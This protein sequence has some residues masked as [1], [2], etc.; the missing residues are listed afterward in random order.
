MRIKLYFVTLI[1]IV[2]TA[3]TVGAQSNTFTYQGRLTDNNVAAGGTYEM[4]FR[5][6][7]AATAGNQL[8]QP[9]PVTLT[10][11]IAGTNP[12]T[13]SNGVFTVK[14]D[15]G[16]GVFTGADRWL[17]IS[18]RKPSDPPGFT[19]LTPRQPITS[20]PYS[21]KTLNANAADSLSSACILC[22]TDAQI[23]GIDGSKVT[24]SVASATT[25]GSATTST[26]AATATNALNLGGLAAN[27][28]LQKNGD[29]SLLTNIAGTFKWNVIAGTSQQAVG[30]NGYVAND[31]GQ[32]TITLPTSPNIGDTIR[33]AAAGIGGFLIAQNAGQ[34]ILTSIIGA[35]TNV[36]GA[37]R[38][39]SVASSSDGT[40]LVAAVNGGQ[41]YT[42]NDSGV[43]WTPRESNRNW[44]SVAS[45]SDGTKLVAAFYSG[46]IYTSTDS[47]VTWFP[48]DS[49]RLWRSVASSSDGTKLVAVGDSIRVYTSTDSGVTWTPRDS[50][51]TWTSVASSSDGTKLVAVVNGGQIYTSTDSGVTWTPRDSSHS[52]YSV[53]SS[54][55]GTKLVA[56]IAGGQIY[57]STDSGVTW[58]PRDSVRYWV[59]VASSSDGT[60]L[61]AVT[62]ND[63]IFTSVDSGVTWTA[64]ESVRPWSSV[65]S[66]SDGTKLVALAGGG[67]VGGFIYTSTNSGVLWV[68][69]QGTTLGTSGN[70]TGAQLATVE[71]IYLGSGRFLVLSSSGAFTVN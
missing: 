31:A 35:T 22:I 53:A 43:T 41:I 42:S 14:L 25:A 50:S 44:A 66:S 56:G 29:G 63:Q 28:Y 69:L 40:K 13:V 64:R 20:S 70:M 26:T 60:K 7:D 45:S 1:V 16:N 8:P 65:A 19:L 55:D 61:V 18:V 52:W 38:W 59:S 5:V 46:Q 47:G 54:S 57:T 51:R 6:F 21:I 2:M 9:T 15:F 17:E 27:T 3:L 11:T 48:R 49:S 34:R 71:L 33:I 32:V 68:T 37:K 10:F 12:V 58:T 4:E 39:S 30:N 36:T 24:G 62:S 23:S 67:D